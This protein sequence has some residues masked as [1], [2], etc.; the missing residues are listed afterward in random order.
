MIKSSCINICIINKKNSF[1]CLGCKRNEYEIFNWAN[2]TDKEKEL[3]LSK[4][5]KNDELSI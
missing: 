5:K 2:F 3:I 1:L 4:L